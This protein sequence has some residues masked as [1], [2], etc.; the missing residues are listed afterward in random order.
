VAFSTSVEKE[1]VTAL[2][3]GGYV[4]TWRQGNSLFF[5]LY[6]GLDE[7]VS[8]P[9]AVANEAGHIQRVVDVQAIGADGSFAI[10]WNDSIDTQTNSS[11]IRTRVF[12]SNGT[13]T[14]GTNPVILTSGLSLGNNETPSMARNGTER[15]DL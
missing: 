11:S 5:R 6:N 14:S 2:P 4:V 13:A 7:P 12:D 1:M 10:S 9:V 15:T 3:N 8:G